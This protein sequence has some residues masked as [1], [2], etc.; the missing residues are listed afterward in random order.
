MSALGASQPPSREEWLR[1]R[2]DVADVLAEF[3]STSG[4]AEDIRLAMDSIFDTFAPARHW[5]EA[6]SSGV[7][8]GTR[9]TAR[10]VMHVGPCPPPH[11]ASIPRNPFTGGVPNTVDPGVPLERPQWWVP[12]ALPERRGGRWRRFVRVLRSPVRVRR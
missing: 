8:I 6:Y 1:V 7:H 9:E 10:A 12:P 3:A 2:R 4:T 11:P 5:D